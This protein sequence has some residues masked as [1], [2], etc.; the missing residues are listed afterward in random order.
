MAR[1]FRSDQEV[2]L[3]IKFTTKFEDGSGV[4]HI[5]KVGD[6]I[7][8]LRYI[9]DGEIV[10]LSGR[11]TKVNYSVASRSTFN[12]NNPT[13]TLIKDATITSIDIDASSEYNSNIIN[14]P[15]EEVVEWEDEKNV[16]RVL[17]E[18]MFYVTLTLNY[19]DR[20]SKFADITVGD[21]FNNVKIF[22]ASDPENLI[23][24]V[25]S[26]K[27]FAYTIANRAFTLTGIVFED[28]A[29]KRVIADFNYIFGLNEIYTY[30]PEDVAAAIQAVSS[31]ADG[32]RF[33]ISNT[34]DNS[35]ESGAI[36]ISGLKDISVVMNSD[37]IT[38]NAGSSQFVVN[39][40]SVT[41]SGDG[42]FKTNTPYDSIHSSGVM[43]IQGTSEVVF[44]G[45][46]CATALEDVDKGQFGIGVFNE[47][48]VTINSGDFEAGWYA[49][50]ENGSHSG[51]EIVINGGT[52]ISKG[53]YT[54]YFPARATRVINGGSFAGVAG[55]IAMNNGSLSIT[56]GTF[57]G[58]SGTL[59]TTEYSQDG[60]YTLQNKTAVVNINAKYGDCVVRITGGKFITS[61][62]AAPV[63][64]VATNSSYTIDVQIS[65]GLF[66]AKFDEGLLVEG[67]KF[68]DEKNSDGFYEVV[69]A[70]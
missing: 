54:L 49:I 32:D 67:Y 33:I 5:F 36:N 47:S 60:T 59:V 17:Y 34:L 24:G 11:L 4:E 7:K 27:A 66:S 22:N 19:S 16:A 57:V 28:D 25:Y 62:D 61:D 44:N 43:K 58:G 51:S 50:S 31:L 21:R 56:G 35:S 52:F 29:G 30:E 14:V 55:C 13:N 46:G 39:N 45:T 70:E 9:L 20:S 26:V 53:D 63:V 23:T 1:M 65:G 10:T 48:K 3:G 40:S 64:A 68:T 37:I 2:I 69:A 8:D 38:T 15:I 18:P 41:F 12:R 6:T 42:K